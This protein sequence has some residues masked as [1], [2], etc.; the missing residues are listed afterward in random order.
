[1]LLTPGCA[2]AVVAPAAVAVERT[3]DEVRFDLPPNPDV[4][5]QPATSGT[6]TTRMAA[7]LPSDILRDGSRSASRFQRA[8]EIVEAAVPPALVAPHGLLVP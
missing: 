6:V 8:L 3:V 1:M 2:D 7:S 4:D 5:P